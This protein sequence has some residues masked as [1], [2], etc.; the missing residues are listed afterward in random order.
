MERFSVYKHTFELPSGTIARRQLIVLKHDDGT[1]T[2]TDFGKYIASKKAITTP[3][4]V[5]KS[6]RI[7]LVR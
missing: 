4:N 2:F 6:S 3:E 7:F 1:L 5:R